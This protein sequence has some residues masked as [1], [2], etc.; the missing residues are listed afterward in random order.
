[1]TGDMQLAAE[2]QEAIRFIIA[3]QHPSG[4]WRYF[5]GQAGD[6][7]VLGWQWMALRSGELA[8]LFVPAD[9]WQR[10]R[11]FLDSVA[12]D[13]GAA[14][15]YQQPARQPTPTAI[16]LAC[17]L[18]GDWSRYDARMVQGAEWLAAAGPSMDDMY[19][20]YY[21]AQ[22]LHH[23]DSPHWPAF[24]Q[25]LRDRLKASQAPGGHEAGS[26]YFPDVHTQPG[27]RLCDTALVLLIL[28]LEHR[29]LPLFGL[30]STG[31]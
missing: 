30:R 22:V 31:P 11:H 27:G 5:P 21:A 29:R 25:L 26:W 16:G 4:G 1:M 28:E 14:Y 19:Y 24:R 7:T 3:A 23:S 15:G 6:T 17:R 8:G 12:A 18:Y 2:A 10:A 9:T 13:G 20:N